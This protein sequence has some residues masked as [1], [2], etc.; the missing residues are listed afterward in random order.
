MAYEVRV[1]EN[2]ELLEVYPDDVFDQPRV[3]SRQVQEYLK[4][5]MRQ[6]LKQTLETWLEWEAEEQI[7]AGRYERGTSR[8]NYRNGYRERSL[9]TTMGTVDL[10]VPRGRRP[11]KF[12]AFDAYKRR[13][14]E[15]DEVLLE[16][17]V[18]GMS[19]RVAGDRLAEM[20]GSS[21]T[22]AT[23]A[24]LKEALAERLKSFKNAPLA[25]EYVALQ[26]DGMYVKIKQCGARKRPVIAVIGTKADGT[27]QLLALRV[28][29]SEN[30]TEVEGIL[31]NLKDRGLSGVN[32]AVVT[33]DGDKGLEA[34]VYA[35]YGNVRIQDCTFHRINRLGRNAESKKR[36]RVMMREASKAF[37]QTDPRRQRRALGQFC[38][39]WREKEPEAIAHFEDRL[40][41]CF[42]V[43]ALPPPLRSSVST[44]GSCE[45]LFKQIRA[46][47]NSI[48][49]FETPQSLE[50]YVY[51]IV[52]QKKWIDI[53]GRV[54]SAPLLQE[55]FTHSS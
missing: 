10:Q 6:H 12:L 22:G 31:R 15:L 21:C 25:D 7:G 1:A 5:E 43:N 45:G 9:G 44:T 33:L 29:Y 46:R 24:K 39:K 49:A 51:A 34:A 23:V 16:A 17:H 53:P 19:C 52:C 14:Q 37:A 42:E 13:W 27:K 48:G 38:A 11:L 2:I 47:T 26:L 50:L 54:R 30:S 40:D 8:E 28:C 32:L 35:V 41:R 18:G 4:N 20:L 55:A 36:G 3:D